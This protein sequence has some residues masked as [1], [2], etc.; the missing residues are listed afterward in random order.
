MI[1]AIA[2]NKRILSRFFN[3]GKQNNCEMFLIVSIIIIIIIII[4]I[5]SSSIAQ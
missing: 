1:F 3:I 5:S 2:V 4:I